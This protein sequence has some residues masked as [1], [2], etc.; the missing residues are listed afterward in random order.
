MEANSTLSDAACAK[1]AEL[2]APAFVEIMSSMPHRFADAEREC[3]ACGHKALA[4]AFSLALEMLDARLRSSLPEGTRAHDRRRRSTSSTMGDLSF[5][6]TRCRDEHG[7]TVVLLADELDFPWGAR[8]TPAAT[9]YLVAAGAEVSFKRSAGLLEISGGSAVSAMPVM[10]AVHKAGGLRAAEDGAMA[11]AL[12]DDG[13]LPDADCEASEIC[14]ES[15]GTYLKLQGSEAGR[16][17]E[18]R[19]MVAYAGKCEEGGK[20]AR[21]RPVRH[22][23]VAAPP[24]FWEQSTAVVGTRFDLSK[25]EL[26]RMGSDGEACYL[27]GFLR[28][29]CDEMHGIDP[30]HVNR[31]IMSCF[32]ADAR[33]LGRNVPGMVIDGCAEEAADVIEV[34]GAMGVANKAWPE[35]ASYLR[36]NAEFIYNPAAGGLGT[37]EAEQQHVY[38]ARMDSVPC[39]WSVRG[40]DAMA[41]IKSR[42]ASQRELPRLTRE[43]SVTPK[44]RE[45]SEAR[46]MSSLAAKIDTKVPLSVGRGREAEHVASLADAQ[47]NVRY[48]AGLDSG[49][50]R[51]RMVGRDPHFCYADAKAAAETHA[52]LSSDG[53][54]P[55]RA[56]SFCSSPAEPSTAL[57]RGYLFPETSRSPHSLLTSTSPMIPMTTKIASHVAITV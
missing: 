44:R 43:M 46:V 40:A 22:G 32:P 52:I 27:E 17:V 3:L 8:I 34:A 12:V 14:V 33:A 48:V 51:S 7:N 57:Q 39:G 15:D 19:S 36:G 10:R 41:R 11:A 1:I 5:S 35:V 13:V 29:G 45:R 4:K 55:T 47:A 23:C 9:D 26:A 18:V 25:V 49:H 2:I 28:C 53:A 56:A 21:V 30:F 20:V 16:S 42:R 37:M 24:E 38:G 50:G 31:K 54:P 6:Y